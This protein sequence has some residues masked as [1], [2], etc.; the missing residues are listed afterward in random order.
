VSSEASISPL[1]LKAIREATAENLGDVLDHPA[2][3]GA[4][5]ARLERAALML[6][7]AFDA[8]EM[9]AEARSALPSALEQRDDRA[10][11]VMLAVI[12][13]YGREPLAR[14]AG[15]ARARL[16][17][18]GI[19]PH[20]EA[21][22]LALRDLRRS[23][24]GDGE[25]IVATLRRPGHRDVQ[26]ALVELV[27]WDCGPVVV[28]G[29]LTEPAPEDEAGTLL[30]G[31]AAELKSV[32]S[33][34]LSASLGSAVDH[35]A[36]HDL[37]LPGELCAVLPLLARALTGN[38]AGLGEL[39]YELPHAGP[40]NAPASEPYVVD[41]AEDEDSFFAAAEELRDRFEA[42]VKASIVPPSPV[43]E[44]G[45]FVVSSM[46]EW[47]GGYGDGR[48]VHWTRGAIAECLL[49]FFPRKVSAEDHVIER[50]P[51]CAASF[52]EFLAAE[53]LLAGDPVEALSG[54][55]A[56]HQPE[57][58][59]ACRDPGN[60]GLAKSIGMQMMADGVDPGDEQAV[61]AWMVDFNERPRQDH[62][63]VVGPAQ[64]TMSAGGSRARARRP[65]APRRAERKAAKAARR[66]N[67][68]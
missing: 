65:A 61:A 19:E 45:D 46:L 9:P 53:R 50:V 25:L 20:G 32:D 35:M 63:R 41:V 62:D 47:K 15:S 55:C 11:A 56:E 34:E 28:G 64:R 24:V 52:M 2:A 12:E 8:P 49:E 42:Y 3:A 6:L 60:W 66:R 48:L 21:G 5:V 38:A 44:A 17:E 31:L 7:P 40:E 22:R 68:G 37:A 1:E 13:A 18:R 29:M 36:A 27:H 23:R 10:A 67:R 4:D 43:W 57:F 58:E 26:A 59:A 30:E 39:H 51:A 16:A 54:F 14:I 33:D